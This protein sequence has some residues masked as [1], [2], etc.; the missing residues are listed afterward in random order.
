MKKIL[1]FTSVVL[2]LV[3]V[4]SP[5]AFG[6]TSSTNLVYQANPL[7]Q[8]VGSNLAGAMSAPNVCNVGF[9]LRCYTPGIIQKAYDFT[10]AYSLLG[11]YSNAGKGEIIIIIDAFGS[12]TIQH[13]LNTFDQAFGIPP[14]T[15]N[16][17]C[18]QGCPSFNPNSGNQVGWSFETTLDVEYSHAMAPAATIDLVV[19]SS[20][21]GN[22]INNAEQ[23]ALDN[24]LGQVWSQSF[25]ASECLFRGDNS[26]FTQAQVIYQQATAKGITLLASAGDSGAQEGCPTNSA[27]FPSSDPLNIAVGG[28]H[29]NVAATGTYK[30][31]TTWNDEEDNFLLQQGVIF[32]FATGGAPSV[33]FPLPSYQSSIS[34][35]PFNCSG[36]TLSTCTT[37]AI[38][39]PFTRTTSDVAYNA[40]L[41]GGVIGYWSAIP[42]QAGFYIFGGT[43]AG[44]PQW[45][46]IV[47]LAD[48]LH[49]SSLGFI[50]PTIYSL[51]GTS[52]LHD[53]TVGSNTLEPGT[54]FSATSGYD[55]PTGVGTPDVGNLIPAL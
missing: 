17:I 12:P 55:A 6:S 15:V 39:S 23:F 1:A 11:G 49:A 53:T 26:Q 13:D 19:A 22:A 30:S 18:P 35:T 36:N 40:D 20:N 14:T 48:Q 24:N 29:L 46:A 43:S 10:G 9:R 32:P 47:A 7:R 8:F 25:G 28:T 3:M 33:F 5:V 16:I 31:E 45:A 42:R 4:M 54:G 44:S 52:A 38:Y 37:G 51:G 34:L 21:F 50:T 2:S 27:I 41:D